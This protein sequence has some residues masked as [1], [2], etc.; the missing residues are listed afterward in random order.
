MTVRL[1]E[2]KPARHSAWSEAA[3]TAGTWAGIAI[4]S[5]LYALLLVVVVSMAALGLVAILGEHVWKR[6]KR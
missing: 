5:L 6:V 4:Q 1:V 2:L 3:A